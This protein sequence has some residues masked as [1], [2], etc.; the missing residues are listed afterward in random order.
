M[1]LA[2]QFFM[3]TFAVPKDEKPSAQSPANLEKANLPADNS[4]RG[5]AKGDAID[6]W[7][8]F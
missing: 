8:P 1:V 3:V 6:V 2:S 4:G 5:C 7:S